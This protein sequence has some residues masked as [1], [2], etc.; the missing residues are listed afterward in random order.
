MLSA[1]NKLRR[2]VNEM[3]LDQK[4]QF[5]PRKISQLSMG[6]GLLAR[7]DILLIILE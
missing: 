2:V 3:E 5:V 4:P 1:Y 6:S 7:F